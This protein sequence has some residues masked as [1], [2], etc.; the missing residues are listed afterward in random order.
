MIILD[1][2]P[3][4]DDCFALLWL[5][6]L[7]QQELATIAAITTVEGNVNAKLTYAAACK[8]LALAEFRSIEV[9]RSVRRSEQTIS[10]AAY[11][12]GTDG[13]GNLS[14]T[15]P[16]P[17]L[18]YAQ[19][20]DADE[21]LVEKLQE[22]PGEITLVAIAPLSN[23]AAAERQAP[24]I[25]RQAKEIVMMGG[26]LQVPG[27]VT[28]LAE[29]NIA[30]DPEAAQVVFNS[31]ANLVL[32]PMDITCKLIFTPALAA[33]IAAGHPAS[34]IAQFIVAL[35][36]FMT[37]TAL[38]YRETA[39]VP[40]FPIHDAVTLAYLFYP[41]LLKFRRAQVEVETGGNWTRGKTV[42][43]DRHLPKSQTNVWVAVGCDRTKV[44][45]ALVADLQQLCAGNP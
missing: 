6:S 28:A 14:Q 16:E 4:G 26:A 12:H 32:L 29:F 7:V 36:Q 1:T 31:Q 40:G 41:E 19:A 35:C 20:R 33:Q 22:S 21:I 34:A 45:A 3:G 30:Y 37:Q 24:G 23:L 10:D 43:D 11:I 25:L 9:G 42:W 15:L 39:G 17:V 44:L 38:A 13:M 18:P 5:L 8:V 2:D 27:N